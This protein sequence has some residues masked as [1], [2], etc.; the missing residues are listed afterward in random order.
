MLSKI[1]NKLSGANKSDTKELTQ[2]YRVPVIEK[3][4]NQMPTFQIYKEGIIQQSDL[5]FLPEDT[6]DINEN[7]YW[8]HIDQS[9]VKAYERN[10]YNNIYRSFLDTD[11][12]IKYVIVDIVKPSKINKTK[13][14][15]Y[16]KYYN[17]DKYNV[18]P[19]NENDYEYTNIDIFINA[20]WVKYLKRL[21][22]ITYN[23][24]NIQTGY[25][26]L[27]VV[28]DDHS[29][30]CD[31][32]PLRDK[33]SQSVINAYKLIYKRKILLIPKLM[34]VD[35]GTEFKG[36]VAKYL[37]SLDIKIRVA[38]AARHRQ[39]AI[40]ERRNHLIGSIIHRI[41]AQQELK[42]K[43]VNTNWVELLPSIIKEINNHL[44]KPISTQPY[45][46]PYS[47]KT[48]E[49]LLEIGSNVKIALN[50]PIN[51]H[52]DKALSGKFRSSDIRWT[53]K[54]YKIENI[55]LKPSQPPLYKTS[56][57]NALHTRQ[58]LQFA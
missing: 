40:V 23:T 30:K 6:S 12:K 5:L 46:F 22:N 24:S 10:L 29:R 14:G 52:N 48:N 39:Q 9:K 37:E 32:E 54:N 19:N 41:Q 2:L 27:L 20:K 45:D 28:V 38:E 47:D 25:K 3:G 15:L 43:K 53:Q 33:N 51:A 8:D 26:Y 34:E 18:P 13:K 56:Y 16:Y 57:D 31:A 1:V 21:K 55:M 44:P 11:D 49:N 58:Q 42:T 7:Q 50:H 17:I 4:Q 35:A 36:D